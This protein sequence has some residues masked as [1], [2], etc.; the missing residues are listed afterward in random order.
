MVPVPKKDR[1]KIAPFFDGVEETLIWSCLNGEMGEAWADRLENPTAV[2]ILTAD[3]AFIAG[4]SKSPSA[5]ELVKNI[6][7]SGGF[8]LLWVS[9]EHWAALVESA[10]QENA[11]RITRY[12]FYKDTVFDRE[13]LQTLRDS[14]PE[15]YHL[16]PFDH[17]LYDFSLQNPWSRDFC[18][19]FKNADDYLSRGIGT[20][21]LFG[22]ELVGG[23]SSYTVYKGGIEIEIDVREDHRRK[24]LATACAADLILRCLDCGLYPSWDAANLMSVGLAKKLGYH[25]KEEYPVYELKL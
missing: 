8:C 14:L 18:S 7:V 25:F 24:G 1:K 22:D 13:R 16:A 2:R 15:G 20:A 9:D 6:N 12:A 11:K 17:R 19:N 23:A 21:A 4:S 5:Y 3:F 10:Y